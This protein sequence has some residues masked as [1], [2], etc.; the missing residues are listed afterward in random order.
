MKIK[1]CPF[2]GYDD[3]NAKKIDDAMFV[4][5]V[6]EGVIDWAVICPRCSARGPETR[7]ENAATAWNMRSLFRPGQ[8]DEE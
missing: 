4:A 1:P 6:G 5:D 7:E 2:C 8:N 3:A